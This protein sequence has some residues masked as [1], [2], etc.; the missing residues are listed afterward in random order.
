MR[1]EP[2]SPVTVTH[3]LCLFDVDFQTDCC[4]C[5]RL[6]ESDSC[7]SF[8]FDDSKAMSSAYARHDTLTVIPLASQSAMPFISAFA[9]LRHRS[10][11]MLKNNGERRHPC[12]APCL[13]EN[14]LLRC[15]GAPRT[16]TSSSMLLSRDITFGPSPDCSRLSHRTS[17]GI[18]SIFEI[19]IC[20]RQI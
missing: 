13:V 19:F 16:R 12:R 9:V 11:T 4:Q 7:A 10:S 8:M 3:V 17:R 2:V 6:I 1:R 15:P 5:R 14:G 18:R 20:C